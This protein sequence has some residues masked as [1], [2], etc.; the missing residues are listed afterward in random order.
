MVRGLLE[1]SM[2]S[3]FFSALHSN[4]H[5]TITRTTDMPSPHIINGLHFILLTKSL[6]EFSLTCLG[7]KF[8]TDTPPPLS[9]GSH[10]PLHLLRDLRPRSIFNSKN[11]L[12]HIHRPRIYSIYIFKQLCTHTWATRY[13]TCSWLTT[14]I[15]SSIPRFPMVSSVQYAPAQRAPNPLLTLLFGLRKNRKS[16]HLHCHRCVG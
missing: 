2:R 7:N 14:T 6:Y 10:N 1:T 9:Q 12:R 4:I 3:F 8:I 15:K 13:P 5:S 11:H 16:L